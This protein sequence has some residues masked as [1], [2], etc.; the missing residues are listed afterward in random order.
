MQ[1]SEEL[2]DMILNNVQL[3]CTS[4]ISHSELPA[5]IRGMQGILFESKFKFLFYLQLFRQF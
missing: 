1:K 3:L 5:F 4:M 2:L